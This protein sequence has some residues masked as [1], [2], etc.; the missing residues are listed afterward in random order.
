MRAPPGVRLWVDGRVLKVRLLGDALCLRRLRRLVSTGI[1]VILQ[2]LRVSVL[3]T[4][5]RRWHL[6]VADPT[7]CAYARTVRSW[8]RHHIDPLSPPD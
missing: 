6:R 7:L 3:G 4:L 2:S 1:A 8:I 5:L